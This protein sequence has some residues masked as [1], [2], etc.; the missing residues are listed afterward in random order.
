MIRVV[1][2]RRRSLLSIMVV[3]G[4]AIATLFAPAT[5]SAFLHHE[6][7]DLGEV[8]DVPAVFLEFARLR[9]PVVDLRQRATGN[10]LWHRC[11]TRRRL[12]HAAACGNH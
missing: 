12:R 6:H 4:G 3:T 11:A 9:A 8:A 5:G 10:S 7:Q 2:Q 1:T